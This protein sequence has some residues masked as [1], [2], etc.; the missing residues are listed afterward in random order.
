MKAFQPKMFTHELYEQ[1]VTYSLL[2]DIELSE[3]CRQWHGICNNFPLESRNEALTI[4]SLVRRTSPTTQPRHFSLSTEN[5]ARQNCPPENS[6]WLLILTKA[7]LKRQFWKNTR[8][9][10]EKNG[11]PRTFALS[12]FSRLFL[13]G[14]FSLLLREATRR[15][16]DGVQVC[17]HSIK[18][19]IKW[20]IGCIDCGVQNRYIYNPQYVDISSYSPG[21]L[22]R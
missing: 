19:F 7:R 18:I 17:P 6:Q 4:W 8:R 12:G 9:S 15:G 14:S 22:V 5:L 1:N 3:S 13:D 21:M 11:Q 2:P 16:T 10:S 20:Y